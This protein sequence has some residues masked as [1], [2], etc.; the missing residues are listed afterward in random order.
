MDQQMLLETIKAQQE[1][2]K[3]QM[4]LIEQLQARPANTPYIAPVQTA[5][6]QWPN[7]GVIN[8]PFTV[9]CNTVGL[10]SDNSGQKVFAIN[11]T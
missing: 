9:T 8:P 5:P 10:R 4:K 6:Y 1:L 3:A 7:T 2:I 11:R